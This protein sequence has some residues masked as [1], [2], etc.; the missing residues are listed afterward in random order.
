MWLILSETVESGI[1][2]S[3]ERG[4]V[5]QGG[6]SPCQLLTVLERSVPMSECCMLVNVVGLFMRGD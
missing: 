6:Q 4:S 1:S 2:T 3:S 5:V